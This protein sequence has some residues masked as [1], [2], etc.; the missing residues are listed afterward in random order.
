MIEKRNVSILKEEND[1]SDKHPDNKNETEGEGPD[2]SKLD[3]FDSPEDLMKQLGMLPGGPKPKQIHIISFPT[4]LSGNIFIN[5]LMIIIINAMLIFA[6]L[7]YTSIAKYESYM[8]IVYF[9][10]IFSIAELIIKEML[11][12]YA[13]MIVL[14]S[15]GTILLVITVIAFFIAD[16]II[17]NFTFASTAYFGFFTAVFLLVRSLINNLIMKKKFE[18]YFMGGRNNV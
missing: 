12:K 5:F 10:L 1:D 4:R 17:E 15:L 13:P 7:G 18:K 14:K 9:V 6:L 8:D 11:F 3:G 2:L 16:T